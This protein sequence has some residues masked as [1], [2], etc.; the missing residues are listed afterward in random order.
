MRDM[1][2]QVTPKRCISPQSVADNTALVGEIID[3]K[4]FESLTYL[5]ATGSVGDAGAEFT[6]LL[7]ESDDSGMSGATAVA[8]AD[9]LGTEALA[10]FIQTDDNKCF[11]LGY[12]GTKRYTRLT[13]TPTNNATAA[14][15]GAIALLG[16][17]ASAP[18]ANPPA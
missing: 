10:S 13:I 3:R 7:E 18:T 12:L 2:N 5:I 16:D 9:L 15:I 14:L 6:A 17:P 1:F 8:N 11:K 4:G